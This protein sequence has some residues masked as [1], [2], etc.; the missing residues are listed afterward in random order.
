MGLAAGPRH[1]PAETARL[2]PTTF[3]GS[4][5][6]DTRV[7]VRCPEET[8]RRTRTPGQN[9]EGVLCVLTASG[10]PSLSG[11]VSV[12]ASLP[13]TQTAR[14]GW[15][16]PLRGA[17]PGKVPPMPVL[18]QG[19][20]RHGWVELKLSLAPV[21]GQAAHPV[22]TTLSP[23]VPGSLHGCQWGPSAPLREAWGEPKQERPKDCCPS[24][25][26]RPSS[27]RPPWSTEDTSCHFQHSIPLRVPLC[28]PARPGL[29]RLG[30]RSALLSPYCHR[31]PQRQCR[32]LARLWAPLPTAVKAVGL[33]E[34][35]LHR[36]ARAVVCSSW[37]GWCPGSG[38]LGAGAGA[39]STESE[40]DCP[41]SSPGG[42]RGRCGATR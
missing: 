37:P 34:Q 16:S 11:R 41:Q 29:P 39:A 18:R 20:G 9:P 17:V 36:C 7:A 31:A 6:K 19:P 26:L 27:L 5:N 15:L 42:K 32:L 28:S 12:G 35:A 25:I 2:L 8:H 13:V 10:P 22:Q 24:C 23:W 4:G 33:Y 1:T 38:H 30:Y 40:A 21:L 3:Q 14:G